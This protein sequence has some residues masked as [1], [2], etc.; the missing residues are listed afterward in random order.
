MMMNFIFFNK[1]AKRTDTTVRPRL[2]IQTNPNDRI[3]RGN[4]H[5]MQMDGR[6]MAFPASC[7]YNIIMIN[8]LK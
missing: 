3:F 8:K 4:P 6:S 2:P 5:Y 1:N 7:H